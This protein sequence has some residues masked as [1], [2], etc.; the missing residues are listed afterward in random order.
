MKQIA[1]SLFFALTALA[2]GAPRAI[3]QESGSAITVACKGMPL[4]NALAQVEQRSSY[5]KINYIYN[6]LSGY[7][8]NVDIKDKN[9]P[10][11]VKALLAGLPFSATTK[12]KYI[13]IQSTKTTSTQVAT[14]DAITGRVLDTTGEAL[15]GVAIKA[16][17]RGFTTDINGR[18]VLKGV[19]AGDMLEF[20]FL[21]MRTL[22]CKATVKPMVVILE[23]EDNKID[24]VVVTG[25][26]VLDKRSL[27]SAVSSIKAEDLLRSDVT[28]IDQMLEGRIP[29]LMVTTNSGEIGVAPKI[30]IRGTSSLIGNREPLWVVD[31]I[32]VKDPVNIS[33]EELN[34]PDYINRIGNAISGINP[35]DID[36][37]DVLKDAAATAIYGTRAAN[38]V[39]VITTKRGYEGKPQ[40]SYNGNVNFKV[41]PRY[42]DPSIDVMSSKERIQFSRDLVNDHYLFSDD[43]NMVGYEGLLNQL[44]NHQIGYNDFT[45]GVAKLEGQNTDWF[46]HIAHDSWS[47]SHTASLSGGSEKSRYYASIGVNSENDVVKTNSGRRYTASLNLDN[48]FSKL[49]TASFSMNAYNYDRKYYQ[50]SINPIDYAYTTSRTIP[51]FDEEGNYSFYNKKVTRFKEYKYNIL[52][53]LDNSSMKQNTASVTATLNLKFTFTDWLKAN[54]IVSYTAQNSEIDGYW[55]EKTFY[56]AT[57]RG[58]EYGQP[59]AEPYSSLLPQGGELNKNVNKDRSVT[60]RLQLMAAKGFGE[61]EK[62]YIDAVLGYE[63]YHDR[64]K[65]YANTSRCYFPDRGETFVNDLDYTVY[66]DYAAWATHNSPTLV[67]QL[68]NTVSAYGSFTYTY[69]HLFRFNV[70]GRIDGSNRF[71]DR[72]N[73]KLLPIWSVS[74]SLD[75]KRIGVLDFDWTNSVNLKGSFG[76]QGNMLDTESP[77]MTIKKGTMNTYY[78]SLVSYVNRFPNPNLEWETTRSSNIGLDVALLNNR[79]RFEGSLFYKKTKDAF[80]EKKISTVNGINSYIINGGNVVN[81]GY[82]FD[83]TYTPIR[84]R[85]FRWTL[86]TSFSRIFNELETK[87]DAQTYELSNFLNGTALVEG[88]SVGTFYSYKFLGLSSQ[89]GGPIFDDMMDNKQQLENLSKYDTYTT[90]L[91]AS[92]RR[93]A[94]IQGSLTNTFR[95]KRWSASFNLAYS[96][97]AKTRL[98]AMYGSAASGGVYTSDFRPDR[99]Y[100]TDYNERWQ[101]PGD[102]KYTIIPAIIPTWS[103]SYEKYNTHYS[104]FSS[105]SGN[106]IANSAWDMY[107][108]CNAR[109]VSAN[110]LKF[111]SISITH[112]WLKHDLEKLGIQRIALT[113]SAYNLF[114]LC[115]KRLKGQTPMQGGFTSIQLS[116]RPSFSLGLNVIF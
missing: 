114:T 69:N 82:S 44:Y 70:N 109:V 35:Q 30:R 25:Y 86:S 56:A 90:V 36:R 18:F 103:D 2:W 99:N 96:L 60:T 74:S 61:D 34:D 50:S 66:T 98:F 80:M 100:S 13:N 43:I 5:Y 59:I 24:D 116:E 68:T 53:E 20:S 72:S 29:D 73:E 21:G 104:T 79:L 63:I 89:D 23:V 12:G 64:Y 55:G 115:D 71:G 76:F 92:G 57:L 19:K 38:G 49:L 32:I 75:L 81:K 62:H 14:S 113:A 106:P 78:N 7:N 16:G 47:Q 65:S 33:P 26:Q 93:E 51:C 67:N 105:Y 58:S 88:Q 28:S 83:I 9:A 110:Y 10:E 97:G 108:Y 48:T 17:D 42:S 94:T 4:T 37:I 1:I 22:K 8:A 54:A 91:E 31:G 107:D 39:I 27:T 40:V 46:K 85:D 11:A 84:T 87:P 95:Y 3:A 112:E 101:K 102:E 52:N 77:V 41:R 45:A 15:P 6:E 111:Q